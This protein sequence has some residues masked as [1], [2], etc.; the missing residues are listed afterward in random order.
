MFAKRGTFQKPA[1]FQTLKYFPIAYLCSD[2][3]EYEGLNNISWFREANKDDEIEISINLQDVK[4]PEW[5]E[6]VTSTGR[7]VFFGTT[8]TLKAVYAKPRKKKRKKGKA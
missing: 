6:E 2:Q 8:N 3:K 4:S 5:P 7:N 1:M